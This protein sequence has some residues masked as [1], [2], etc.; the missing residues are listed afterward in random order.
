MTSFELH[1]AAVSR[2]I[3]STDESD[4]AAGSSFPERYFSPNQDDKVPLA[5]KS[6][7]LKLQISESSVASIWSQQL[8]HRNLVSHILQFGC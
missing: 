5:A 8:L 1:P 7:A 2:S 4:P 3:H 6:A